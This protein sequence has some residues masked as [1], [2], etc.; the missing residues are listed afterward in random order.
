MSSRTILSI[1]ADSKDAGA[2]RDL[3]SAWEYDP[4]IEPDAAAALQTLVDRGVSVMLDCSSA[5]KQS[6]AFLR[7]A[8]SQQP[9]IPVIV[10]AESGSIETAIQAIQEE[11][12]YHYFERPVDPT[13]LKIVLDRATEL[14][15]AKKENELLRRQ[16]Q[17]RGALRE[18]VGTSEMMR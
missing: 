1:D 2:L 6:F 3:V 16:L 14:A 18:L 4:I 15:S 17:D 7:E 9:N 12:A 8:R 5:A 10:I 13:K 11:G